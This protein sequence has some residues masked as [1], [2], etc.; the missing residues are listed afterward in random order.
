MSSTTISLE[1]G[2]FT[3]ILTSQQQKSS[4]AFSLL[5]LKKIRCYNCLRWRQLKYGT[6]TGNGGLYYLRNP[7]SL[8]QC[9]TTKFLLPIIIIVLIISVY[10]FSRDYMKSMLFWIETQSGWLIFSVFMFFFIIVSFPVAV[11]YLILILTSGYLFG[12]LR[13]LATVVIGANVG[14]AVAHGIIRN[15]QK[16]LPIQQ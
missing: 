4:T 1:N 2:P 11:G 14:A 12:V 9:C 15:F 10:W 5:Q 16:K 3:S 6:G 8:H 7:P 13:G